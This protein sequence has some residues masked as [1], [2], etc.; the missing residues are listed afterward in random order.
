MRRS[1]NGFTLTLELIGCL[2][3]RHRKRYCIG[4]SR[5]HQRS[6][7][8]NRV[9]IDNRPAS[10]DDRFE[11]GHWEADSIVSRASKVALNVVLKRKNRRL[12]LPKLPRKSA[13]HTSSA[14]A[15]RLGFFRAKACLSITYDNGTENA[16]H[17]AVNRALGTASYFCAPYHSW[18]K[19]AEESVNG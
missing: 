3:R 6:H 8:P 10:V 13:G 1:T 12:C 9:G 2:P 18:E 5:K 16:E 4:H 15:N 7:I 14:M 11:F 17:E 19:G